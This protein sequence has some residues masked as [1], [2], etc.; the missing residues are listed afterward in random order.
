[1]ITMVEVALVSAE[2]NQKA[3]LEALVEMFPSMAAMSIP[4]VVRQLLMVIVPASAMG[5]VMAI[6]PLRASFALQAPC[7]SITICTFWQATTP[8]RRMKGLRMVAEI[9]PDT[10]T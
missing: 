1:M 6:I 2:A 5:M 4:P 8:I 9:I 7:M 10:S 3:V